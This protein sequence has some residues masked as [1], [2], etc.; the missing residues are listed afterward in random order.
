M[1][2]Y[3]AVVWGM[4]FLVT[5]PLLAQDMTDRAV[6][7]QEISTVHAGKMAEVILSSWPIATA[8]TG[9]ILEGWAEDQGLTLSIRF[10]DGATWTPWEKM[11]LTQSF[12]DHAF[13][14]GYRSEMVRQNARFQIR[15][16]HDAETPFVLSHTGVFD[17][18]LD[19]DQQPPLP[20]A[21]L[22]PP[23][24]LNRIKPPRLIRRSEWGARAFRGSPSQQPR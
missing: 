9:V 16:T 21:D 6:D 3:L 7:M 2:R 22:P 15:Y 23:N 11:Y 13:Y 17:A 14:A 18:R 20:I 1:K 19:D 12:T 5:P 4:L 24:L 8:F 10:Q